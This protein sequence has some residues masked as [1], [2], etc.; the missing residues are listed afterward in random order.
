M[1][2][3]P[4]G[5]PSITPAPTPVTAEAPRGERR[6]IVLSW[7]LAALLLALHAALAWRLRAPSITTGNDDAA[8]LLLSRSLRALGYNDAFSIG[9]P[10][11]SQY[12]PLYPALLAIVGL[13]SGDRLGAAIAV[14]ILLSAS[15]LAL[16]YDLARRH[17]PRAALL[18][19]AIC[20]VNPLLLS[21]ASN[22]RSEP[23]FMACMALAFWLLARDGRGARAGAGAAAIAG[24]LARSAGVTLI[25]AVGILWLAR[26]RWRAAGALAL[27]AALTVGVWLGWTVVA[28]QQ[29]AGL[30]YVADATFDPSEGPPLPP[31][32]DSARARERDQPPSGI[33]GLL[34][35]RITTNVP[36]YAAVAVPATLP[37]PTVEGTTVDN[38]LWVAVLLAAGVVG[39]RWM[40]RRWPA[41][42]LFLAC[43]GALLAIWPYMLSRFLAPALPLIA[44]AVIIGV[45]EVGRRLRP[46][47]AMALPVLLTAAVVARAGAEDVAQLRRMARCDRAHPMESAGCFPPASLAYFRAAAFIARQLPDSARF[48]TAKEATFYYLT[49]RHT[50][51]VLAAPTRSTAELEGFL[52]RHEVDY[53]LLTR[54]RPDEWSLGTALLG[55]CRELTVV[56]AWG[57]TALLLRL[58]PPGAPATDAAACTAIEGWRKGTWE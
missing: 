12:P 54:L 53:V 57:E 35:R 48:L 44:L 46:A 29:Y 40:A 22:I 7:A 31:S 38:W 28:P 1:P 16:L 34:A 52:R 30:S 8:Y 58:E 33:S 2:S 49:R 4:A 18:A 41:C 6:R 11:H 5:S 3:P 27:A 14:N 32:L 20:A 9:N 43:Y 21:L 39:T 26:R 55:M 56:G 37:V 19:L 51:P 36:A 17:A 42:V 10:I 23:L 50:V 45:G 25:A 15:A 13:V 24:A 47:L